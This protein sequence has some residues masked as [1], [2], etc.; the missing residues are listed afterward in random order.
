MTAKMIADYQIVDHGIEWSDY[1]QG[2]GTAFTD[3][4]DVATGCGEDYM[5]ALEDA[6]E[7]LAQNDWDTESVK[8]E[9][10]DDDSVSAWIE[11]ARGD[12]GDDG[13]SEYSGETP[14]Y[15][16]SVRVR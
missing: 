14:Y 3:Y 11:R 2:C 12:N 9:D 4:T 16:V 10:H 1:F 13:E 6:L 5:S 15:Y 7:S 8:P